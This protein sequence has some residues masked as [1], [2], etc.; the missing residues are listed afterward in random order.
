MSIERSLMDLLAASGRE[1]PPLCNVVVEFED[2][3]KW[4]AGSRWEIPIVTP[5]GA[6]K[7]VL[8]VHENPL[9][10]NL[11]LT[12]PSTAGELLALFAD[13]QLRKLLTPGESALVQAEPHFSMTQ[14]RL[15]LNVEAILLVR[16]WRHF[17]RRQIDFAA[18]CARKHYLSLAKGV[19]IGSSP[20]VQP[21][22]QS[23]AGQV[24]HDL[25]EA[26]AKNLPM[27]LQRDGAF[28]SSA[29]SP[30]TAMRLVAA[31]AVNLSVA[32][33]AMARGL[34]ALDVLGRS[35]ALT[36][37]LR[38]GGPW[39]A[40]TSAFDRGVTLTPD[41]VGNHVV[42][43]LKRQSP[44]SAAAHVEATAV[45]ARGYLAWAMVTH[46][47]DQVSANWRAAVVNLHDRTPESD[48]I[49]SL[50]AD[51]SEIA[52]RV[53]NRHR[54]VALADG[55]WLPP[56]TEGECTHCE[57]HRPDPDFP[58]L[59]PAC[60]FHCQAERSWRC[61]DLENGES[62]PLY[63]NCGEH[64]H[65]HDFR[66]LDL[67]NRLRED[68]A[69]E[70]EEGELAVAALADSTASR[71]GPF[72]VKAVNKGEV[73]LAP[74]DD[75]MLIEGAVPGQV[76][77]LRVGDEIVAQ[78]RFR[79]LRD[80]DWLLLIDGG[81]GRLKV[82]GEVW[83][84]AA[85]VAV[86]PARAQLIHLELTQ[87]AGKPAGALHRGRRQRSTVRVLHCDFD[88]V[89][90]EADTIVVDAAT[91]R[92]QADA[93]Q[94]LLPAAPA[95]CLI[96]LG[97][98]WDSSRLPAGTVMYDEFAAHGWLSVGESNFVERAKIASQN[99]AQ[100]T[101]VALPWDLLNSGVLDGWGAVFDTVIITDAHAMPS[102]ALTRAVELRQRRL[103]LLGSAIAAGPLT[104]AVSSSR[105]PLF[106]NLIQQAIDTDG[107][108]LPEEVC[109]LAVI[110]MATRAVS[111]VAPLVGS[112]SSSI[113]VGVH[114]VAGAAVAVSKPIILRTMVP[115]APGQ[116]QAVRVS[117][118]V[119]PGYELSYRAVRALLHNLAPS[120]F[121]AL[122]QQGLPQPGSLDR[123]LL[124]QRIVIEAATTTFVAG[125]NE[126]VLTISQHLAPLSLR[127]GLANEVEALA[128]VSH[129]KARP[130]DRFIATSPFAAQCRTIAVAARAARLDNLRVILPERVTWKAQA[131]RNDLLLSLS[132]TRIEDVAR[133][134][135]TH[136]GHMLP[137]LV[138][139]WQRI[140]L[141]CSPAMSEH[142]LVS[143]IRRHAH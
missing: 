107:A 6:P 27:A 116:E 7:A 44:E 53:L 117:A 56:P 103:V 5:S 26:A 133:W 138:G 89:P 12:Y 126:L 35:A 38:V 130:L 114:E 73:R 132:V 143:A 51:R 141:F 34:R 142:P 85:G 64:G 11:G 102:L 57:F 55:T 83:L 76:F 14:Q 131:E 46:G 1:L 127:E 61:A 32:V 122:L 80:G 68:L 82:K 136:P 118:R 84:A 21:T 24:A 88:T 74:G 17:G 125:H 65:Y 63:G 28:I 139:D 48:R 19:R 109:S 52:R 9:P 110:Q 124:G 100:A 3:P 66:V 129:A 2:V 137:L 10:T 105:S 119:A 75:L 112:F 36:D 39:V 16:P 99:L 62:C 4:A 20:R 54:L 91:G 30:T 90:A 59:A 70:D 29:L 41:L 115:L 69:V 104:E 40:E 50:T 22:W 81:S 72:L 13:E 97:A 128:A 58:G 23:L 94:R 86:Y 42:V 134:P 37:L 31:G 25:I 33:T 71:W 121:D 78:A 98:A 113:P 106:A 15:F 140:D 101:L 43:E 108:L 77:D 87:R 95:R 67:F 135:Y 92:Q 120:A 111:G 79:R 93:L 123:S 60:Q 18:G 47:V 8:A 49:V 96:L 45:Q